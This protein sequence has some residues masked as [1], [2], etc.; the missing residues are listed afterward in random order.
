M[1]DRIESH[2]EAQ[3]A[4]KRTTHLINGEGSAAFTPLQ[5]SLAEYR[6]EITRRA[7]VEAG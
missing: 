6:P 7:Y 3:N 1:E 4:Q 5:R 2:K